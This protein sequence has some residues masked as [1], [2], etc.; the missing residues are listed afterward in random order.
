MGRRYWL[1]R[2]DGIWPTTTQDRSVRMSITE[3][4]NEPL[5]LWEAAAQELKEYQFAA[6]LRVQPRWEIPKKMALQVALAGRFSQ[7]E[8]AQHPTTVDAFLRDAAEVIAAGASGI[9]VDYGFLRD[10]PR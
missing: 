1:A 4:K 8:A 7:N 3:T 5:G 6:D 9:H 10:G 2:S